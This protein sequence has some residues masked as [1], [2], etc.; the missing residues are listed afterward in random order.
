L[1]PGDIEI[2]NRIREGEVKV[3]ENIFTEYYPMLCLFAKKMLGDID[4]ARDIVQDVFVTLYAGRNSLHI[5][6]S[7][8]SYLFKCV[9]NACLNSLKQTKVYAHHHEYLKLNLPFSDDHDMVIKAELEDKIR[10]TIESLPDECRKIFK[11]NRF[12]GKKNKEIADE[13]NISIRTVETQISKALKVLRA[14]L[15]DFLAIVLISLINL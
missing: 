1:L 13:L 11:M 9:Y 12:E 4:K 6:T 2:I 3:Y 5:N 8:K 14:N 15:A 7:L 10:I